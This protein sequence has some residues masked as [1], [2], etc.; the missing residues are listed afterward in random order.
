[1][2]LTEALNK[3]SNYSKLSLSSQQGEKSISRR[4]LVLYVEQVAVGDAYISLHGLQWKPG[5]IRS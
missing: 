1:M 3:V 5:E 2:H 4:Q